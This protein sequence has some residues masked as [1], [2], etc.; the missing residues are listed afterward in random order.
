MTWGL[1][2]RETAPMILEADE[3]LESVP[4]APK[5]GLFAEAC[6]STHFISDVYANVSRETFAP[7]SFDQPT[8]KAFN[9]PRDSQSRAGQD[10]PNAHA[11][12]GRRTAL[13]RPRRPNQASP[14]QP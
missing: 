14:D 6:R 3:P 7:S 12:A 2:D 8:L 9:R 11:G 1:R 10:L 5:G 13:K 4:G